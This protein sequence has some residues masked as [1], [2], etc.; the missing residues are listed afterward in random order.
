MKKIYS[1]A[2][3]MAL[4]AIAFSSCSKELEEPAADENAI[5][6][7]ITE[8]E[9]EVIEIIG[10]LKDNALTKTQ[11]TENEGTY[12]FSWTGGDRIKLLVFK[13]ANTSAAHYTLAANSTSASSTFYNTNNGTTYD[14]I[15]N[16]PDA[17]G[18]GY[19]QT[20][21]AIYPVE[22]K[23]Y[24][25]SYSGTSNSTADGCTVNV[26]LNSSYDLGA[27]PD[28]NTQ[29][30]CTPLVG[31]RKGT[32]NEYDFS[33]AVGV[34][35]ITLTNIPSTA[36]GLKITSPSTALS[37][38]FLLEAGSPDIK[39]DNYTGATLAD[40]DRS[41]T[42]TFSGVSGTHTF[43][44]PVPV[45]TIP[46]VEGKGLNIQLLDGT[47]YPV[48]SRSYT[49]ELV[50]ER[51]KIIPVGLSSPE[52]K[53]LGTGK[54][55]DNYLWGYLIKN[56]NY[57]KDIFGYVDV[58]I[59]QNISDLYQYRITSP[60]SKA[61]S[62]Y[63][64]T[65]GTP[66]YGSYS[67]ADPDEYLEI[68]VDNESSVPSFADHVTGITIDGYNDEI[69]LK[70]MNSSNDL[71]LIG[72]AT[73]PKVI[74]L[75]PKYNYK[76][77][78][79]GYD[80]SGSKNIIKIIFP[81][82]SFSDYRTSFLS[83]GNSTMN[84]LKSTRGSSVYSARVVLSTLNDVQ[85]ASTLNGY[86]CYTYQSYPSASL[87]D[88]S[89]G[90]YNWSSFVT[91]SGE[92][93][94]SWF[95]F[96]SSSGEDNAQVIA[97][98]SVK[99]PNALGAADAAI[100]LGTFLRDINIGTVWSGGASVESRLNLLGGNVITIEA[101][102]DTSKGN[103][104][105]TGFAGHTFDLHGVLDEVGYTE[106]KPLYGTF[107]SSTASFP[108]NLTNDGA[109]YYDGSKYHF[110]STCAS[111]SESLDLTVSNNQVSRSGYYFGN[112]K[113]NW[114]GNGGGGYDIYYETTYTAIKTTGQ[115][116]LTGKITPSSSSAASGDDGGVA[117]LIDK[118]AS[119]HWHSV[120]EGTHSTDEYGAHLDIDL[121][122]GNT[123]QNFTVKF[124]SRTGGN[125]TDGIP[126]KYAV[127]GS[128]DN[129]SWVELTETGGVSITAAQGKWYQA[130]ITGNSTPY[131]YI[132]FCILNSEGSNNGDLT[133]Q[134]NAA[135]GT[136]STHLAELQLWAN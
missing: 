18:G 78:R 75:A 68:T 2:I 41:R 6:E 105:I 102:D 61:I 64:I 122:S 84:S 116:D 21:F 130:R 34:L 93:Y 96:A 135:Y 73:D 20:G 30:S 37:G 77:D 16:M 14:P 7:V 119:T 58:D 55:I 48:F 66:S 10:T 103:I 24:V 76:D 110:I 32:T 79:A 87:F 13:G 71:I 136:K 44:I 39:S 22:N 11:Y 121:G 111:S 62:E 131:R 117:A 123:V 15:G 49:K 4:F 65:H 90:T 5:Q 56:R 126:S 59:Y 114:I 100:T 8:D 12:T 72:T 125:G 63:S 127:Y 82:V 52:W 108:V 120:W 1:I 81:S 88:R 91:S 86:S 35:A 132:R 47:N 38:T 99:V 50:V 51:N 74:Q 42:V 9:G 28:M 92:W 70:D 57:D 17:V 115:I 53:K 95:S 69:K 54:F 3:L 23:K 27:S 98:G 101:S 36:T 112:A 40:A 19:S 97:Q 128:N 85:I 33:T 31:V 60:Y 43:Y 25:L 129:S 46:V 83:L 133:S 80:L 124:L 104:M 107:S 29:L 109:F 89:D 106:G 45:G 67:Y 113:S 134:T 26:T 118:N 94:L